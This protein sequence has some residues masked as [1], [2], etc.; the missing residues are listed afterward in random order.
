MLVFGTIYA[1]FM[2]GD[3][4]PFM[5][6]SKCSKEEIDITVL[7]KRLFTLI[8]NCI[9]GKSVGRSPVN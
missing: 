6:V 9:V 7:N 8:L 3:I 2:Y 5:F 4:C 1:G